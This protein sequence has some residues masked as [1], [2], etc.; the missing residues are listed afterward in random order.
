M[1]IGAGIYGCYAALKLAQDN[2][3]C[4]ILLVDAEDVCMERATYANQARVHM[5]YHY[6]RSIA[7][8]IKTAS[9]FRRF[10]EEYA[11]CL[12]SNF[13]QIYA[14]SD[15]NSWTDYHQFESFCDRAGIPYEIVNKCLFFNNETV[16]QA[17]KVC[18]YT[19]DVS[20]LRDDFDRR[21]RAFPSIKTKYGCRVNLMERKS[22]KWRVYLSDKTVLETAKVL[23][24]TYSASNLINK[25]AGVN[26]FDIKYELCEIILC[27]A[28]SADLDN[29]GITVMDGPFFSIMPF[30]STGLH[31]L[32]SVTFTPHDTSFEH[33]PKFPCQYKNGAVCE[34]AFLGNC[35]KCNAKPGTSW[36]YMSQLARKYLKDNLRF[37]YK[38]SLFAIKPI[39]LNSEVDDSRP[40]VIRVLSREPLFVS[41]LSGKIN[42]IYDLD[43]VLESEFGI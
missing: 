38:D 42:T 4:R 22:G 29:I 1:I 35:N 2:R 20:I 40:T 17:Y 16:S 21:I 3:D 10:T 25:M 24:A 36:I 13:D 11:F 34:E 19:Y 39:L 30:G 37:S 43:E 14:I 23:N 28:E 9:Y 12:K 15:S 27:D 8:A 18:E 7:T 5:G 32:T 31:S 26:A 6:P 33:T 41:V